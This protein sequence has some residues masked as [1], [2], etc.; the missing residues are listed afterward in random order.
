MRTIF[1][2]DLVRGFL[3]GLAGA[4]AGMGIAV[5]VRYFIMGLPAWNSGPVIA[6]G[7][8]SGVAVYLITLGV[9]NRWARWLVGGQPTTEVPPSGPTWKRYF[10]VD[11]NHKII[12]V[13]Y[14]VTALAFLPVGIAYQIIGRAEL[15][16]LTNLSSATYLSIISDHGIVLLFI[17][18]L[19]LWSGIMNYLVPLMIGA[20][21]MA[22]PR[23]NAFSYWLIPPAGLLA[24]LALVFGGFDTGWTAYPPLSTSCGP[25]EWSLALTGRVYQQVIL[26]TG[27]REFRHHDSEDRSAQD[28]AIP[29]RCLHMVISC[30]SGAEP[31]V[32][33]VCS[34]LIFN[35]H[36]GAGCWEWF[37]N[38]PWGSASALPVPVLVLSH[39]QSM[40]SYQDCQDE[41]AILYRFARKPLFGYLAVALSSGQATGRYG[42]LCTPY[43]CGRDTALPAYTFYDNDA[44]GGH[45]YRGQGFCLAATMDGKA[46][47][48]DA[49]A[50]C[51]FINPGVPGGRAD[52]DTGG[53]STHR[54]VFNG[55]L[56]CGGAFSRYVVWRIPFAGDGGHLLLVSQGDRKDDGREGGEDPMGFD[57]SRILSDYAS[58]VSTGFYGNEKESGY[59][60][61][62][63]G[64]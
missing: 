48:T 24:V 44:A 56:F 8:I 27:G 49:Y 23:L 21:D 20:R 45:T 33:P 53:N 13:Q 12:G 6:I 41:S 3:A 51:D 18:V 4:A 15:S 35:G 28:G 10:N 34:R 9:F 17:V 54:S 50:F 1:S 46:E 58:G 32:Y 30:N 11:T 7:I 16:G 61:L 29:V 43:V 36:A 55:Y 64:L 26:H 25:G 31:G 42:G 62:R 22:F 38:L 52:R 2:L 39:R 60:C 57:D 19:P 59:L 37:F 63:T 5:A 14:I 40:S 47:F